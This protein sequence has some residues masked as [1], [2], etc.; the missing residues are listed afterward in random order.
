M[1]DD[2]EEL[3]TSTM[4]PKVIEATRRFQENS[5][6]HCTHQV[7]ILYDRTHRIIECKRCGAV[8]DP[9]DRIVHMATNERNYFQRLA[10]V[11]REWKR[12]TK[13]IEELKRRERN[14]RGRVRRWEA[15]ADLTEVKLTPI[16]RLHPKQAN[17]TT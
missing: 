3:D 14:A 10:I 16:E 12:L 15:K 5:Q 7:G 4:P 6:G 8:L 2:V 13:S 9:F 1:R 17:R 11:V